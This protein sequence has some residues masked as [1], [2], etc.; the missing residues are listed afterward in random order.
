MSRIARP[1]SMFDIKDKDVFASNTERNFLI[2][3]GETI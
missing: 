2:I 3:L 1:L